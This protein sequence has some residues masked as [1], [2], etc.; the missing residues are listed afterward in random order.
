MTPA[1]IAMNR[2][3]SLTWSMHESVRDSWQDMA[4]IVKVLT[5]DATQP[6]ELS[7]V[8]ELANAQGL[9]H[10][11]TNIPDDAKQYI[12]VVQHIR[13]PADFLKPLPLD[14]YC[15]PTTCYYAMQDGG[16]IR[17]DI[18]HAS[19][20]RLIESLTGAD[21]DAAWIPTH[22]LINWE[23]PDLVCDDSGERIETVY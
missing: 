23:N 5:D 2:D 4:A 20:Y 19:A 16:A 17:Y 1:Y 6:I 15:S 22:L 14:G 18:A 9:A 8:V 7:Q 3:G 10:L 11:L 13:T 12:D 21:D